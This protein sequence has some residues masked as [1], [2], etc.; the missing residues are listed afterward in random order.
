VAKKKR[1]DEVVTQLRER[2]DEQQRQM[3]DLTQELRRKVGQSIEQSRSGAKAKIA[4]GYGD[5]RD[6]RR[7]R[8]GRRAGAD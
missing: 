4:A 3:D 1:E 7:A 6:V 8:Q 5:P 2:L